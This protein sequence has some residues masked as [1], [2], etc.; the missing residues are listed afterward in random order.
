MHAV[1]AVTETQQDKDRRM[2]GRTGRGPLLAALGLATLIPAAVGADQT[3][4][5]PTAVP[6]QVDPDSGK[7]CHPSACTPGFCT[8]G[9][10]VPLASQAATLPLQNRLV[11]LDCSPH[12]IA[13]VQVFAEADPVTR[14]SS[15]FQ[16]Y[17]LDSTGFQP[18]VFTT[19][20]PGIN[21][22]PSTRR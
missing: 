10:I 2:R 17:L 14:K 20:I 15:L 7:M 11:L 19:K 1:H 12:S 21:D 16:Y 18:S 3:C 13:P 6:P 9:D 5:S 4:P 22:D 8:R